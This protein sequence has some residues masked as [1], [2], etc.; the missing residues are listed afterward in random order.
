MTQKI[1]TRES[2]KVLSS[3]GITP[4]K[5]KE[6]FVKRG[7]EKI[8]SKRFF[9]GPRFTKHSV[10]FL[11]VKMDPLPLSASARTIESLWGYLGSSQTNP[12]FSFLGGG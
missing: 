1:K 4:K 2:R 8:F 11:G 5:S 9:S 7:P 12:F 6:C 10:D 3:R